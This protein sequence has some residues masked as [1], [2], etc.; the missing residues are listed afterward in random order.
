MNIG[1]ATTRSALRYP[2]RTAVFQGDDHLTWRQLDERSNRLANLLVEKYSLETGDRVVLWAPNR[3]HVPEILAGVAKAG[4]VYVGLNFRMTDKE[5]LKVFENS[6][7]RV[8]I[9]DGEYIARADVLAKSL[10]AEVL[11]LDDASQ[12]DYE[13]ILA[14][15]SFCEPKS[16]YQIRP[17]DDFCIIYTSGT[18]GTP[19]DVWF[20]HGRVL[21]HAAIAA[22]EYEISCET[23]YL[24]AIPHNS[25]VHITLVP[26][27]MLGAAIGFIDSRGFDAHAYADEV[28]RVRAAHSYLVP[29]QIYRLLDAVSDRN[30]LASIKTLGYG[31][32][33][34]SPD[35]A[36][37]LIERFGPIFTQ[38]YGMAEIA[39][40]GT[41]LRKSDHLAAVNGQLELL[42][43]V[44]QSSY[45]MCV[46]VLNA[47]GNNLSS[48]DKGEIIFSA[49]YMMK[50]YFRDKARTESTLVNG[51][52]HSG[53]VGRFDENGYLYVVDR[54]KDLIIRGGYNIAPAEIEAAL[55]RHP[56]VLEVGVIGRPDEIWGESVVAVVALKSGS[57]VD[58]GSL[59]Q[60]CRDNTELAH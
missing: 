35:K 3:L 22:L 40:I 15:A 25:S 7:P 17:E 26:C 54:L 11:N 49:P 38:L 32:A 47:N 21:Q 13:E 16:L 33:P 36:G 48:D 52:V 43:S 55:H 12:C 19:K 29:T 1:L 27:M 30:A 20:D 51:W 5:L 37:Q 60:W 34:M 6:E 45:S 18:T 8:L 31:A 14:E 50:G 24:T 56:D 59:L 41:I 53:D 44:G 2:E 23:R 46:R 42:N 58:E 10:N 9:V 39:S 4:M 28:Q 57:A